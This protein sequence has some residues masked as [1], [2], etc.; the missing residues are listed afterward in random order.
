MSI[1]WVV[2]H[3]TCG[4]LARLVQA[5]VYSL[6]RNTPCCSPCV[7]V[8]AALPGLH[9]GRGSRSWACQP[10]TLSHAQAPSQ[11]RGWLSCQHLVHPPE[12]TNMHPQAFSPLS[13]PT[14]V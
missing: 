9:G 4:T 3:A 14:C 5:E 10:L 2:L 6:H 12:A 11:A 7:A 13:C 8:A 1:S